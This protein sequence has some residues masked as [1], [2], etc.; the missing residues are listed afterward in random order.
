MIDNIY[1]PHLLEDITIGI[2]IHRESMGHSNIITMNRELSCG[3]LNRYVDNITNRIKKIYNPEDD[4]AAWNIVFND[5]SFVDAMEHLKNNDKSVRG[6]GD[7]YMDIDS[8]VYKLW[9]NGY[10]VTLIMNVLLTD[11]KCWMVA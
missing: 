2:D 1:P 9:D 10:I 7:I 4:I 11:I 3:K 5:K 6:Q 8:M